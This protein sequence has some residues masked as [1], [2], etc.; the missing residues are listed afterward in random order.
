MPG[1]DP[2]WQPHYQARVH[3]ANYLSI[4]KQKSFQN[5]NEMPCLFDESLYTEAGEKVL[6]GVEAYCQTREN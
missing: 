2:K 3:Q 1:V 5:E 4:P 6:G